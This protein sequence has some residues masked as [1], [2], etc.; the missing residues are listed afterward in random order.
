MDLATAAQLD[1][2][3]TGHASGGV[4]A[5]PHPAASNL[6]I[7]A[8]DASLDAM[9]GDI[10]RGF[11]VNEMMGMGV[12]MVTAITAAAPPASG[13]RTVKSPIR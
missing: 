2:T 9:I 11:L 12:N 6:Y 4:G 8:G 10:E 5:P 7:A 3:T 13:S 1:L